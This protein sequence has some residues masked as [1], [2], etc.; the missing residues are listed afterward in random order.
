MKTP[1]KIRKANESQ[2]QQTQSDLDDDMS[3]VQENTKTKRSGT[4]LEG[5]CFD[6]RFITR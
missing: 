1:S 6:N 3:D 4:Y 2:R 5:K